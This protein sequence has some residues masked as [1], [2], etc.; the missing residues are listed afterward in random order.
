MIVYL[1][2]DYE[3][4]TKCSVTNDKSESLLRNLR[5]SYL[6]YKFINIHEYGELL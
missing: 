4:V 3:Y 2:M 6:N 5:A 1:T